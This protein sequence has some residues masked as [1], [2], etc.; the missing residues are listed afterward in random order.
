MQ[1]YILFN[2][3]DLIKKVSDND[4]VLADSMSLAESQLDGFNVNKTFETFLERLSEE[5]SK[6][7]QFNSKLN[8]ML[9]F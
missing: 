1:F 5:K 3:F 8:Q 7:E 9:D 2:L 6:T 4:D